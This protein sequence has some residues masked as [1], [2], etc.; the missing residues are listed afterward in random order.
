MLVGEVGKRGHNQ[1]LPDGRGGVG[2]GGVED[3]RVDGVPHQPC[4]VALWG[5]RFSYDAF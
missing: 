3:G 2:E 4:C 1:A 5:K